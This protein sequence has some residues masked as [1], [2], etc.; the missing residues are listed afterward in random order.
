MRIKTDEI[1]KIK[2]YLFETGVILTHDDALSNTMHPELNLPDK[3]IMAYLKTLVSKGYLEKI[4]V[5]QHGYYSLTDEGV[6]FLREDL[7]MD[8]A[9][10]PRTHEMVV[11]EVYE[12]NNAEKEG[13]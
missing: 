8:E 12:K 10:M 9:E 6:D 3:K 2:E 7:C 11:S 13:L 5:W 4:F 1:V